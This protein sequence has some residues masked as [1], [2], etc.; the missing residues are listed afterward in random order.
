MKVGLLMVFQNFQDG[1]TDA[2]QTP[3]GVLGALGVGV[4]GA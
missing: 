4:C 1:T 3:I 2:V